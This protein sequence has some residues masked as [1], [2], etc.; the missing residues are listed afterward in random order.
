M[1]AVV[2]VLALC[3]MDGI[4][5]TGVLH[6]VGGLIGWGTQMF[7]VALCVGGMFALCD[8]RCCGVRWHRA[9]SFIRA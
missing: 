5:L 1:L 6:L 8:F 9:S 7:W 4:L 2:L 3:Q